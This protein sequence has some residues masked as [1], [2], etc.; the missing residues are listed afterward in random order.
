[1]NQPV[2]TNEKLADFDGVSLYPSSMARIPGYLLGPPKV[3]HKGVDVRK[4][5]GY[6]L[7]IKVHS[8][9]RKFRFPLVR[10]KE[11]GGGN[12]WT[13]DLEG[14]EVIVDRF[15]LEDLVNHGK[16]KY[17]ILQG[18]Y[19]DEGRNDRVNEVIKTMFNT[20]L[21]YKKEGNPLQ[22]VIKLNLDAA[23]ALFWQ[24]AFSLALLANEHN[25]WPLVAPCVSFRA[26]R[27]LKTRLRPASPVR[28]QQ[29]TELSLCSWCWVG[30]LVRW[31]RRRGLNM[32]CREAS[33]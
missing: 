4:V 11:E 29:C 8:V 32:A 15:T 17:S 26:L 16:V 33:R 31:C 14:H 23:C 3:W 13:N 5:D 12:L 25:C 1:M 2:R 22:L 9:G 28:G 30:A 10:L 6:F 20:R 27:R 18:Y 24:R 7:K 21:R 19:F